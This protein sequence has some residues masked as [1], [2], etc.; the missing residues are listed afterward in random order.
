MNATDGAASAR[1]LP[2]YLLG[3]SIRRGAVAAACSTP[4]R[5]WR[6]SAAWDAGELADSGLVEVG[7]RVWIVVWIWTVVAS[8]AGREGRG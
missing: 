6:G 4:P 2:V 5:T 7:P 3:N 8:L 1:A